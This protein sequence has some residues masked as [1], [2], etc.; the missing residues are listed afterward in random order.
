[1]LLKRAG[2]HFEMNSMKSFFELNW[3]PFLSKLCYLMGYKTDAA[4]FVAKKMQ[5]SPP[6]MGVAVDIF[7]WVTTGISC[8]LRESKVAKM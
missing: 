4:Q 1:M 8:S 3:E 7:L 6:S 2:R 5:R